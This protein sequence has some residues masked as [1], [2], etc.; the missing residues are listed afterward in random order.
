[1]QGT[2]VTASYT[3][4]NALIGKGSEV[5]LYDGQGTSRQTTSSTGSVTSSRVFE[6]FGIAGRFGG[7]G[8]A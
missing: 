6:G 2:T 7:D 5:N 4:G 1:M 3:Y 8:L